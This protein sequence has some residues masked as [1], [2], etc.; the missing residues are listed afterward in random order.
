MAHSLGHRWV[1]GESWVWVIRYSQEM[2][3][4]IT[5]YISDWMSLAGWGRIK[6]QRR[7]YNVC[8]FPNYST[9]EL[10]KSC[11]SLQLSVSNPLTFC[12]T[13]TSYSLQQ[14]LIPGWLLAQTI[15][16]TELVSETHWLIAYWPRSRGIA[17][18][19]AIILYTHSA[20]TNCLY[21]QKSLIS[22]S[23]L[24]VYLFYPNFEI[25]WLIAYL[26]QSTI[27]PLLFTIISTRFQW[28][29]ALRTPYCNNSVIYFYINWFVWPCRCL[30]TIQGEVH[31]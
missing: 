25:V 22:S 7:A 8:I 6:F 10:I 21:I 11:Q 14:V 12:F 3:N 23:W 18:I 31:C 16:S 29:V 17:Y 9:L 30:F 2:S 27:I 26:S 15:N 5:H 20:Y 24:V 4:G 19:F 13:I 28:L 1:K